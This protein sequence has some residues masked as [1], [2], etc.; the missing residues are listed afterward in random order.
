[1]PK[2]ISVAE[3]STLTSSLLTKPEVLGQDMSPETYSAFSTAL[4]QL[5]CDF[6]GGEIVTAA[7]PVAGDMGNWCFSVKASDSSPSDGGIWSTFDE[8]GNLFDAAEEESNA[9]T[10][11]SNN[12][13]TSHQPKESP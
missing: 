4:A 7:E 2:I 11:A 13:I 1:M 5:L 9:S 6:F 12:S 3:L 8:E 10:D